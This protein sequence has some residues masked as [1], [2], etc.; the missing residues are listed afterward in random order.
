MDRDTF[1]DDLRKFILTRIPSVPYLESLILLRNDPSIAWD[2]KSLARRVYVSEKKAEE[3]LSE[4]Q[5]AG[6]VNVVETNMYRFEQSS[7]ELSAMCDRLA[8]VY[9]TNIVGVTNLIH[10]TASKPA[11]HFADAFKW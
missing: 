11:Q 10:S 7:K 1:P 3:L 2:P 4:L 5:K 6:F 8:D 9:S